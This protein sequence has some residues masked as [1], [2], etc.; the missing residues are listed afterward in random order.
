MMSRAVDTDIHNIML[1][2]PFRGGMLMF[3]FNSTREEFPRM[4][5]ALR[6]SLESISLESRT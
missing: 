2:T 3:N 1:V 6:R 4:E 5:G